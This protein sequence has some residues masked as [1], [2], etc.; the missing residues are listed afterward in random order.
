M[1]AAGNGFQKDQGGRLFGALHF[2]LFAAIWV[3]VPVLTADCLS[4]ER[5][6]GTLGLLFLTG[7]RASDIVVAKGLAHGLRAWTLWL[8]VLPVLAIPFLLGG[9]SWTEAVVLALANFS[10]ICWA[11]AAGLLAS[12]WSTRWLRALIKAILLAGL[13]LAV[14]GFGASW[15]LLAAV[16]GPGIGW[17]PSQW[18]LGFCLEAICIQMGFIPVPRGFPLV[19]VFPAGV[20]LNVMGQVSVVSLLA[21]VLAI[22]VA[23]AR[24]RRAWQEEPPS[25]RQ[26]WW[27]QT[28]CTPIIL[29][30]FY[31]RWL[32]RKLQRN[33]I[34]W[35]EQRTWSGRLVTWGWL[36]VVI[37]LYSA[38]LSDRNFTRSYRGLQYLLAW[39]M[40]GSMAMTASGS[41]RRE[42]ETGV[43]E[44]LL[45]S[46]LGEPDIIWGRLRGLWTQF[47]PAVAL[48]LGV[49]VYFSSFLPEV[50][51]PPAIFFY[52]STFL[53]VPVIGLY[54][55]LRCVNFIA[56]FLATLA[57]GLLAPLILSPFL[58]WFSSIWEA[59]GTNSPIGIGF[60]GE[61]CF[62]QIVLAGLCWRQ[63]H[64]RLKRRAF[65][66]E[67]L[68]K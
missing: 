27:R 24:T 18:G 13:F 1:F 6:E 11:L 9:V 57:I 39:L 28:F 26:L 58:G 19:A 64:E 40:A 37:A 49:W 55:S 32:R 12:A 56:A 16:S 31:H 7:L 35:L 54:F 51:D 21:L 4:R 33:P 20:L 50:R 53:T 23:G 62:W 60:S 46:P 48:L 59:S 41:F 47:L 45:V 8:A 66:L 29:D 61:A 52:A 5:R 38:I 10:A 25:Q 43:M 22:L 44:L 14:L 34:G 36:A 2:T 68:D 17:A 15:R 3:L 67:R 30:K 42:R 63:L 65:P